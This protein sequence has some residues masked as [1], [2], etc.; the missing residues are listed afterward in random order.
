MYHM[1]YMTGFVRRKY[2]QQID[3]QNQ[4]YCLKTIQLIRLARAL[5]WYSLL[6]QL[7]KRQIRQS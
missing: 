3:P 6:I 1:Q 2:W 5:H 7:E 4:G